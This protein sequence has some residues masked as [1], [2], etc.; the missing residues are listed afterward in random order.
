MICGAM[1]TREEMLEQIRDTERMLREA[2]EVIV[3]LD[4]PDDELLRMF[5]VAAECLEELRR[6]VPRPERCSRR[7]RSRELV[8]H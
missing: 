4:P 5:R 7:R 2:R 8:S 1:L 6:S 3:K